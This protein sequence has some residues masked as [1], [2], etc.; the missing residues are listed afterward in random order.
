MFL[1]GNLGTIRLTRGDNCDIELA[2][3]QGTALDPIEYILG[4]KDEVYFGLMEPNQPFE[5]AIL[6]RK[7]TSLN[8]VDSQLTLH[9]EPKD[10]M[11]LIPGL[12]YYQI[13]VRIYDEQSSRYIVN[14]IIPKTQFWIEE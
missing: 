4:E 9:L 11:C 7:L 14:T 10:T 6:K 2:I 5:Q 12:Y 13:K 3:N 8:L 1:L